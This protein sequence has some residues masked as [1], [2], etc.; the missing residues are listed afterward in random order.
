M[1][2]EGN[3][4]RLCK[5]NDFNVYGLF[6]RHRYSSAALGRG[7]SSARCPVP[8]TRTLTGRFSLKYS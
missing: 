4:S 8:S 7:K 3:R 2:W 1:A 5:C 6:G